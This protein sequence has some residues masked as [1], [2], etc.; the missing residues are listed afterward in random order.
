[1]E[2]LAVNNIL[3]F[4]LQMTN[5]SVNNNYKNERFGMQ[6]FEDDLSRVSAKLAEV[7]P[8]HWVFAQSSYL[9]T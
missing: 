8:S 3:I 1:M 6:N 7:S 2:D 5:K 9:L 4:D